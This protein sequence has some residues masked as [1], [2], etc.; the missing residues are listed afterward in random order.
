[1]I[2]MS[3]TTLENDSMD[4][5]NATL[6]ENSTYDS[7]I[8]WDDPSETIDFWEWADMLGIVDDFVPPEYLDFFSDVA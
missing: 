1:M 6:A 7:I 3:T 8:P 5:I 4:E 2:R